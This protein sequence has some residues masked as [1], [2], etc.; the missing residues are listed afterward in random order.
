[1]PLF[2]CRTHVVYFKTGEWVYPVLNRLNMALRI[3]FFGALLAV[4]SVWYFLG[5]YINNKIWGEYHYTILISFSI[6]II[7]FLVVTLM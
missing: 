5:E 6:T 7:T 1:M 3:M 4:G 2:Y